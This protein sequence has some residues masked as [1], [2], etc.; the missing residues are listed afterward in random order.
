MSEDESDSVT[1]ILPRK[2]VYSQLIA[3]LT[4]RRK[5][6]E[7]NLLI[8]LDEPSLRQVLGEEENF[9][10][11]IDEFNEYILGLGLT[12]VE[13]H[14]NGLVWRA[15][16][17]LYSA[18]IELSEEELAV[19][20]TMIMLCDQQER[21]RIEYTVLVNYLVQR[22][23]FTDYRIRKLIQS[24]QTNGYVEREGKYLAFG[25]RTLIEFT[26]EAREQIALQAHDLLF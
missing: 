23:F 8:G 10:S 3:I 26:D 6:T 2:E 11:L 17:S 25:P 20:G 21:Q 5:S 12:V 14:Y 15:I 16:K 4:N 19:L 24:L 18:P 1:D 9:Q 7:G 13:F 22:E